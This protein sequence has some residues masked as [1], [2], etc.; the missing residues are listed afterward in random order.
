VCRTLGVLAV[1]VAL[2]LAHGCADPERERLKATTKPS[3]DKATGKL[4]ELTYDANKNGR[5][6]TW[7][8]M[9]GT[10]PL[11]SRIDSNEDG[12]IDRWEYYDAAGK[13]AKVGFSRRA[14]D[15]NDKPD[16]WAFANAAGRIERIEVSSS[17]DQA[18]VDRWEFFDVSAGS[19]TA[20][21]RTG[22]LVRVEAD[23]NGDGRPDKWERYVNGLIQAAEFDENRDGRPDRRLTYKDAELVLVESAPDASGHYTKMI[24]PK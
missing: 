12:R 8:E 17:G 4:T 18:K 15:K 14:P 16:A 21:D 24:A 20:A 19:G 6:D 2:V 10:R 13:L 9:D 5:I 11:R 1:A 23:T 7:T 22:S 3:Y